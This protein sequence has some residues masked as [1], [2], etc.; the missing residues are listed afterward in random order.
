MVN[1]MK[2]RNERGYEICNQGRT[3]MM[4]V[5]NKLE[6]I[7]VGDPFS[8]L[9]R[10]QALERTPPAS[11]TRQR[12][13]TIDTSAF[14]KTVHFLIENGPLPGNGTSMSDAAAPSPTRSST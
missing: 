13:D 14:L 5:P 2:M 3:T 1:S 9:H 11:F 6:I 4:F 8:P 12:P 7:P 10:V